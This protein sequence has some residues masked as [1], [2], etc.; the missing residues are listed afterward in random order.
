MKRNEKKKKTV[1]YR[2]QKQS[3][4]YLYN[5]GNE[6]LCVSLLLS[7]SLLFYET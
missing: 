7:V 1:V 4:K 6:F 2:K 3:V 5:L